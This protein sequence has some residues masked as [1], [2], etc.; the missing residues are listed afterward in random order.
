MNADSPARRGL[1]AR[2]WASNPVRYVVVGGAAFVIDISLLAVFYEVLHVPLAVS[3]PMAF[4]LSFA[5]TF[6]LQRTLAF[7]SQGKIGS[8]AIRYTILVAANTVAT[9]AIVTSAAAVGFPWEIGKVIAVG[10]TTVW[11]YFAYRHWI[12]R[13]KP[14]SGESVSTDPH[15]PTE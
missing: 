11:N 10:S 7:G 15:P 6:L 9:T 3:T 12:F 4:L 5:I 13:A 8:S 2:L 14:S 1:F